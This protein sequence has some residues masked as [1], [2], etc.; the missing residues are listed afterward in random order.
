[1]AGEVPVKHNLL[2]AAMVALAVC[3]AGAQPVLPAAFPMPLFGV[4][5][6][7]T[8]QARADGRS[9]GG[10]DWA[11]SLSVAATS[12]SLEPGTDPDLG[13]LT[14]TGRPPSKTGDVN[15]AGLLEDQLR[16]EGTLHMFRYMTEASTRNKIHHTRFFDG[17]VQAVSGYFEGD[18]RWPDGDPFAGNNIN[19]PLQGAISSHV[20]TNNDRR[21]KGV[22]YGDPGYW[23]CLRRATIYSVAAS[24]NWEW[25]PLMSE[26]ALGNVG[27]YRTCEQRKCIGEGGWSDFV[28]TPAGG[29]GIR[30]AGDIARARLWP[31]LDGHLSG[32]LEARMLGT[33]VK[34]ATDPGGLAARAFS[35][36]LRG[37]LSSR[38]ASGRR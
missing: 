1:M 12:A 3:P 9:A 11:I 26:S 20:Y 36:D 34:I 37:A 6:G 25:N 27:R 7:H 31:V 5:S 22:Q 13:R 14:L 30:L 19:H 8:L 10:A 35:G 23:G 15:W 2:P 4:N 18:P 28:M 24:L 38:P 29:L 17:Y 16:V 33:A 21:C 32:S